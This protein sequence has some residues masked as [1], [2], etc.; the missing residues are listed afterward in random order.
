MKRSELVVALAREEFLHELHHLLW[1]E[2]HLNQGEHDEGWNCRDHALVVAGIAQMLGFKAALLFGRAAFIQGPRNDAPPM[3]VAVSTHAWVGVDGAG[4]YDLSVRLD[5]VDRH[6]AWT[7]WRVRALAGDRFVPTGSVR[8]VQTRGRVEHENAVA[9]ASNLRAT[10]SAIYCGETYADL[11][12]R[13]ISNGLDVCNSP[14]T[15]RL[16]VAFGDRQDLHARA[17]VHLVDRLQ[18]MGS[19]LTS[20][21]QMAAWAEIAGRPGN[22]VWRVCSRGK[23]T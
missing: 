2:P 8:F 13:E 23:L 11:S 10:N 17:I 20:L 4:L 19:S 21:S 14:L 22:A 3:G 6:S 15:E 9:A 18:G 12:A 16:R 5:A 1:M 7:P